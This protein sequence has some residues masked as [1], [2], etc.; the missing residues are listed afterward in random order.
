MPT[1]P[2]AAHL[3]T[4]QTPLTTM[5]AIRFNADGTLSD[6]EQYATW[7]RGIRKLD[8]RAVPALGL[9]WLANFIDRSNI[10]NAKVAGLTA[11]PKPTGRSSTSPWPSSTS[12]TS[13]ARSRATCSSGS[14][15]RSSGCPSS[16]L[17]GCCDGVL[18]DR[19]ELS[20]PIVV[21]CCWGCSRVVCFQ[22]CRCIC[23]NCTRGTWCR[24]AS[25][26]SMLEPVFP[27]RSEAPC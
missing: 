24:Y 9:L 17:H 6:P 25:H 15:E 8:W 22:G 12:R 19:Q 5:E 10:G 2:L 4:S 20:R 26:S 21:S 3:P 23:H 27:G 18:G 11:D 13:Q 16:Y 14:W 7:R 1:T